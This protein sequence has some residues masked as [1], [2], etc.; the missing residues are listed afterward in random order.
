M[1]NSLT[2]YDRLCNII[3]CQTNVCKIL[4][5]DIL[6]VDILGRTTAIR[7]ILHNHQFCI[8]YCSVQHSTSSPQSMYKHMKL[9]IPGC[10]NQYSLT[11]IKGSRSSI[12]TILEYSIYGSSTQIP[13]YLSA[14]SAL[15]ETQCEI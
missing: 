5:V 11:N 3:T 9:C 12:D 6:G 2:G 8:N 13:T 15:V 1:W 14:V 10:E 4:G 7:L